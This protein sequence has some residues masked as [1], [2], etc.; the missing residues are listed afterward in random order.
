MQRTQWRRPATCAP[1]DF[2]IALSL[3]D[4]RLRR[5]GTI[6]SPLKLLTGL[7][8]DLLASKLILAIAAEL[9]GFRL[10]LYNP[11]HLW[12]IGVVG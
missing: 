11:S 1:K 12:R 9:A 8:R 5:V 10:A 7:I 6:V 2:K 4:S 3:Q